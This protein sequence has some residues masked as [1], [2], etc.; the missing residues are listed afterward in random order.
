VPSFTDRFFLDASTAVTIE[1]GLKNIATVKDVGSS[2]EDALKWLSN[3][4]EDWLLL[5][6]NT[7]DPKINLNRFLPQ[8]N[9]GNIITT[10][11]NPELR[12]YAGAQSAVSDMEADAVALLLKSASELNL[13]VQLEL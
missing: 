11:R 7:D 3:T 5:Y 9:H 13:P 12:V 6:D 2:S 8:C 1:T 4:H 10:S